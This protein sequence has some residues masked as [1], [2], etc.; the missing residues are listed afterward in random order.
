MVAAGW[1][2]GEAADEAGGAE[3]G[4][5]VASGDDEELLAV[6]MAAD[7]ELVVAPVDVA[8]ADGV[9]TASR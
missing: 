5:V 7:A 6:E 9:E 4:D 3:D 8:G 2:D 1:V